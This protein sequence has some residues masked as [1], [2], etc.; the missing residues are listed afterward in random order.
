MKILI[1]IKGIDI[2][3]C[4]YIDSYSYVNANVYI[5]VIVTIVINMNSKT[6]ITS[7]MIFPPSSMILR[8]LYL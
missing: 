4:I 8:K 3:I 1:I 7:I 6:S 2:G 5:D